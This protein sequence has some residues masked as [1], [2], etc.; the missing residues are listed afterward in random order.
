MY[1]LLSKHLYK[2]SSSDDPGHWCN[3][4]GKM[5]MRCWWL[6]RCSLVIPYQ[7]SWSTLVQVM[8][9]CLAATNHY[10]N[11]CWLTCNRMLWHASQGNG[12]LN[13]Q[14]INPQVVFE[15]TQP[16]LPGANELS[17]GMTLEF[18]LTHLLALIHLNI[19]IVIT[20][21]LWYNICWTLTFGKPGVS[22]L[23]Y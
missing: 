9:C 15:F 10:L 11:Q 14:G 19:V 22:V 13:T 16:H 7:R 21:L 23:K 3:V 5:Q 17:N 2:I 20:Y 8:A 6:T 18:A 12:Y 1:M 4:N